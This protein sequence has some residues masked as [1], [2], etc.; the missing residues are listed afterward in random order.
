M[1]TKS[2]LT[3]QDHQA[4]EAQYTFR[5]T[6]LSADFRP[7]YLVG[8]SAF[9]LIAGA[10]AFGAYALGLLKKDGVIDGV[11]I[12]VESVL[13]V[14]VMLAAFVMDR[15]RTELQSMVRGPKADPAMLEQV[16]T[17]EAFLREL[18]GEEPAK[19][20]GRHSRT[21]QL[22]EHLVQI[23]NATSAIIG[24][25]I[26]ADCATS[27][28]ILTSSS[29]DVRDQKME[30]RVLT[31]VRDS[32]SLR[33]RTLNSAIPPA[34]DVAYS[35]NTAF[36]QIIEK[37]DSGGYFDAA[38]LWR[39]SVKKEYESD[40]DSWRSFYNSSAVIALRDPSDKAGSLLG[41]LCVNSFG[42]LT[43]PSVRDQL[44]HIAAHVYTGLQLISVINVDEQRDTGGHLG[45]LP[46]ISWGL[47]E[48]ALSPADA[49][50]QRRL[51][52][53]LREFKVRYR[54]KFV[55]EGVAQAPHLWAAVSDHLPEQLRSEQAMAEDSEWAALG[56]SS[57]D[58]VILNDDQKK[59][60]AALE[61]A[62]AAK[63]D[64]EFFADIEHVAHGNPYA[65]ELIKAWQE[66]NKSK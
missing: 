12:A 34:D 55:G 27:I 50:V 30:P 48:N 63:S 15:Q 61:K 46:N 26:G 58:A 28:K 59:Q 53:A 62:L 39:L 24:A 18:I 8:T 36:K 43:K 60:R 38:D 16:K 4:T 35:S 10:L 22:Y 9:F 5:S 64:S 33:E 3:E 17:R 49:E 54:M 21:F 42:N 52:A 32:K 11:L 2:T 57:V 19:R 41:F 66:R 44:A 40:S 51:E 14:V 13:V 6:R 47:R 20:D 45:T 25:E 31:I 23:A 56:V 29:F 37:P 7:R 1:N 65:Q